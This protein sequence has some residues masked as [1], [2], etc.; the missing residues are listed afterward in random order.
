MMKKDSKRNYMQITWI[1]LGSGIF[2]IVISLFAG[3]YSLLQRLPLDKIADNMHIGPVAPLSASGTDDKNEDVYTIKPFLREVEVEAQNA[4][5]EI[6]PSDS[7]TYKVRYSGD[8]RNFVVSQ[9]KNKLQVKEI[10]GK[11]DSE[12]FGITIGVKR[13]KG[14]RIVLE[15]PHILDRVQVNANAGLVRI[16]DLRLKDLSVNSNVGLVRIDD[17]RLEDLSV[18]SNVGEIDL[19]NLEINKKM[20]L[21]AGIGS[22]K[23]SLVHDPEKTYIIDKHVNIGKSDIDAKFAQAGKGEETVE[24]QVR[25]NIGEVNLRGVPKK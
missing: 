2:L 4:A 3:G 24:L 20:Y 7:N 14:S 17:L 21:Y 23:G 25:A 10:G 5:V 12:L 1:L 9:H 22:I 8:K 15:V 18:N 16:D 11:K 13:T 6:R 19:G